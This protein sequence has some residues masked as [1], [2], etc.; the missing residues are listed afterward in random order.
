MNFIILKMIGFFF[1]PFLK[2][3]EEQEEEDYYQLLK[4]NKKSSLQDIK[5]S[6]RKA[7]LMMH[8]DKVAQFSKA[9]HKTEQEIQ[10]EFVLVKEAYEILSDPKK[11]SLYDALGKEGMKAMNREDGGLNIHS[12]AHNLS[13]A[14]CIDRSKL[15]LLPILLVGFFLITP[16]LICAKVDSIL[17]SETGLADVSW[18]LILIPIWVLDLCLI[19][20]DLLGQDFFGVGK[21]VCVTVTE[22]FLALRWDGHIQW[23]YS[24]VLIPLFTHQFL[25]IWES[26]IMIRNSYRDMS[27]MTTVS[28]L[29]KNVIPNF[30]ST[31]CDEEVPDTTRRTYEDLTDEEKE[32]I[33]EIYII[34]EDL[35][36]EMENDNHSTSS[37]QEEVKL[38]NAIS[39][40][41]EFKLAKITKAMAR[42][43][44]FSIIVFHIA[45]LVLLVLKLDDRK[46]WSW[47]IV[48]TP[49]WIE[50]CI[51]SLSHCFQAFC[52]PYAFIRDENAFDINHIQREHENG[53][54]NENKEEE[55]ATNT[56]EDYVQQTSDIK[57]QS[58]NDTAAIDVPRG[59]TVNLQYNNDDKQDE[60]NIAVNE[61][62]NSNDVKS[63]EDSNV[64]DD[65][66][67]EFDPES[68]ENQGTA[69]CS[70]C[71]DFLLIIA[72]SLFL[73]KLD[74]SE[75]D[76]SRVQFSAFWVIFPLLLVSGLVLLI[77]ACCIYASSHADQV[78]SMIHKRD[79]NNHA[80][81]KENPDISGGVIELKS[82]DQANE[83]IE[84]L[85]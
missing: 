53:N 50:L 72:L 57:L 25:G 36:D 63:D 32:M 1:A 28:W 35:N 30:N 77:F 7:S 56:T 13:H 71:M 2:G 74:G 82:E 6:Y 62:S 15:F 51:K 12:L 5:K 47:H 68:F 40:S 10:H 84:D 9:V 20:F 44:I 27:R 48:F 78:D 29:E 69:M 34:I 83:K 4:V 18:L 52:L 67:V 39:K 45:F 21:M 17:A 75:S 70:C 33:N 42:K 14:S 81:D 60:H 55:Y 8:P 46:D 54:I 59:A 66:Y 26:T 61:E 38:L 11:R 73:V 64:D 37:L 79:S 41:P 31:S 85:D 3:G 65:P 16:I 23:K 80:S 43:Q 24:I 22:V 58:H 49:L 19:I 76:G